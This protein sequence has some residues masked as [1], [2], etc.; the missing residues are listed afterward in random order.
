MHESLLV[1]FSFYKVNIR[2]VYDVHKFIH[3]YIFKC[4]YINYTFKI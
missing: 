1:F 4:T 2:I 3:I